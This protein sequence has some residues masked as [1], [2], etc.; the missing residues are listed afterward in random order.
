MKARRSMSFRG[1]GGKGWSF[2]LI[3]VEIEKKAIKQVKKN[4]QKNMR[5]NKK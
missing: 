4:V 2:S 5:M 3:A 1:L